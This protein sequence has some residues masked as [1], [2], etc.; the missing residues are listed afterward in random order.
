LTPFK[1]TA[2]T[3]QALVKY[4]GLKDWK[5]RIPYH[6][7]ISVNTTSLGSQVVVRDAKGGSEGDMLVEGKKNDDA[8]RRLQNVSNRLTGKGFEELELHLESGNFPRL[9][10]KGLGFSSS[11]GAALTLALFHAVSKDKPDYRELSRVARLFAGSASRT[12]VGG[13]SRLYAGKGYEDTYAQKFA[14]EKDLPLR[15][16]IVPLTSAVRTEDAHREVESSPFFKSRVESASKRCEEMERAIKGGDLR[17][18]GELTEKDTLE[19]HAVTMTGANRLV[20]MS[21]DTIRIITKV[22]ELRSNGVEA[23]FSMQTGPSVFINT[24]EKDEE[25]V[26]SA[27]TR[28]GYEAVLSGVGKAA[29]VGRAGLSSD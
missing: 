9:D 23:Y 1:S 29:R 27:V 2:N 17:K 5:L 20:I 13:F 16:V 10:A 24:S 6:D 22:R 7:S 18:V 19:L 8:L 25:R 15:M 21:P 12:V 26:R 3:M 11:A 14:D 4:H 28:M